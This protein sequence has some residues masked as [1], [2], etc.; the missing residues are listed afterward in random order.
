MEGN[1]QEASPTKYLEELTHYFR[2]IGVSEK[3]YSYVLG[4]AITESADGWYLLIRGQ[5]HN[6]QEFC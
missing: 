5:M 4:N 6:Y 2:T 3:D 1:V